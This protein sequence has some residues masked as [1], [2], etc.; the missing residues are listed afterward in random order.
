M[1]GAWLLV[2]G[3]N[4]DMAVATA[5]RFAAEGWNVALASRDRDS[6]KREAAN[7]HLRYGV[8]VRDYDFDAR[9]FAVHPGFYASLTEKPD[10]VLLAFGLLVDQQ[11]AQRDFAQAQALLETNLTGAVSILEIVAADF[12]ARQRGLIVGISSVAGDRGRKSN[13]LYGCAKAGF[14]A[15]L[16]GLRHRLAASGVRVMTVKPGFVATK[17]T[18]GLALPQR[19]LAT[20]EEVAAAIVR[21][22]RKGRDVVYVKPVWRLIMWLV[23]HLPERIFV[24][25]NL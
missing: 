18:A 7:L 24:K 4:S 5:R 25:T 8:E 20:P 14:S 13:Y 9:D 6:L 22:V 10:A 15:Y 3:A 16:S 11:Q 2:L 23:V 21:G 17:M 19:L 1:K 12:E